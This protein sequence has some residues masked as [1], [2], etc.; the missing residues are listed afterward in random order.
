MMAQRWPACKRLGCGAWALAAAVLLRCR[1][2]K[3]SSG[4]RARPWPW[5]P[6]CICRAKRGCSRFWRGTRCCA[7]PIWV[8]G[9]GVQAV[10][11]GCGGALKGRARPLSRRC[12]SPLACGAV[13]GSQ[14]EHLAWQPPVP[15]VS[16]RM[17]LGM[18]LNASY[19]AGATG[20]FCCPGSCST[21]Q[22]THS[23]VCS[24]CAQHGRVSAVTETGCS[25]GCS[26]CN[27]L[28]VGWEPWAV[29]AWSRAT[30]LARGSCVCIAPH[31]SRLCP[32]TLWQTE[33]LEM[34]GSTPAA[35]GCA[36]PAWWAGS[37]PHQAAV[38]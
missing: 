21:G 30:G 12:A 7:R 32:R 10:G 29:A 28:R 33:G 14:S 1:C 6:C 11:D 22:P 9:G 23:H 2:I 16:T 38:L 18:L 4:P 31:E 3:P 13:A 36:L 20:S 5:Q 27:A 37:G 24:V 35:H 15:C 17:R 34:L 19:L 26:H 25:R 8:E